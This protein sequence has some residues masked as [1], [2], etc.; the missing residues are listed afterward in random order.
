MKV[1]SLSAIMHIVYSYDLS[2]LNMLPRLEAC[3]DLILFL[4]IRFSLELSFCGDYNDFIDPSINKSRDKEQHS[5]GENIHNTV[6]D[7][8]Q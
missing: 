5:W 8:D 7:I 1:L 4:S 6:S 2:R 3:V